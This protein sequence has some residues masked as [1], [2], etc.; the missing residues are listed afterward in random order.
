MGIFYSWFHGWFPKRKDQ[1]HVGHKSVDGL[2]YYSAAA[3]IKLGVPLLLMFASP[4]V[5]VVVVVV[6]FNLEGLITLFGLIYRRVSRPGKFK[7]ALTFVK[8]VIQSIV[9]DYFVLLFSFVFQG[10]NHQL[11]WC[12][13]RIQTYIYTYI[14][15]NLY[16]RSKCNDDFTIN[17]TQGKKLVGIFCNIFHR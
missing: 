16:L 15:D 6:V 8:G 4:F 12:G 1:S 14:Y 2:K 3:G 5:F 13:S 9:F 10:I 7:T 17:L 11:F